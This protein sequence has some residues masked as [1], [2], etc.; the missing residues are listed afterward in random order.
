M[1]STATAQSSVENRK[2]FGVNSVMTVGATEMHR[3][4]LF[5]TKDGQKRVPSIRKETTIR[6]LR[7]G[8]EGPF[9]QAY[10]APIALSPDPLVG[11]I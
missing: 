3:S 9:D 2:F 5:I 4:S 1:F 11:S 7:D 8:L 6:D 10:Y